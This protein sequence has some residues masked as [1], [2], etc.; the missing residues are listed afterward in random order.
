[1]LTYYQVAA[2]FPKNK[3]ILTYSSEESYNPGDLVEIPL[4]ARVAHGV[5]I[6]AESEAIEN[7]KIKKILGLIENAYSLSS[8][9]LEL[10]SWMSSYYH[11]PLGKLIFDSLPKVL[12]RPRK[13]S[14]VVGEN[15]EIPY[16][17]TLD[18]KKIYDSITKDL[19]S[20]Y[21]RH[22][23]HGVTGS[24][25][26]LIY[27]S[28]IKDVL[29]SGKSAQ[30]LLPEI[31]LTPQFIEMFKKHLGC[32]IYSYHSGVTPSEKYHIWKRLKSEE[33]PILVMGVRSSLFLPIENLGLIVV[34]EEHD[35]SF[36][37]Q[38][39]CPYNA[40]DVALKKGMI[41]KIPVILGSATPTVENFYS[42][43]REEDGRKYYPLKNRVGNGVLPKLIVKDVRGED[44]DL[45]T[46]PFSFET[47]EKIKERLEAGE[48]VLVFINKLG[49]SNYLQCRNCGHKFKNDQCGCENNLRYFKQKNILS[50]SHCDFTMKVPNSC[51]EC[52]SLSLLT[53]GFGTE[54]VEEVL[55]K[56]LHP[57][58]IDR[59]DRD[60]IIT[61]KDLN[62]KLEAFHGKKIDVLVGTQ[63]LSKGHNF[64]RV[65]LVVILGFDQ[66]LNY[67]DFRASEKA[68][69]LANQV[70]G[71]AGRYEGGGEVIIET[72]NPDH[73]L[74]K[75]LKD[76]DFDEFYKEE[77]KLRELCFCPPYS[78]IAMLYFS[79]RF[80]DRLISQV[81]VE[82]KKLRILSSSHFKNVKVLGPAPMSIEK[83]ANAYTW[84]I[85]LK[86]ADLKELHLLLKTF[87]D[88]VEEQSG[89]SYKIDVD[90]QTII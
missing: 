78:R 82:A 39:R 55:T 2:N 33:K 88:N 73:S 34:D 31:N 30:F 26:S 60:E 44:S 89:V 84:A 15:L 29:K 10:Y 24:G 40:R 37:Q 79:S 43:S 74:F 52:G 57:Y 87:V 70:M 85:M 58:K 86:S 75:Y 51:P 19:S 65:N 11:Y 53:K 61:L 38:D 22:Y 54:R 18:Q 25:K 13:P 49:F 47:L 3:S 1:M 41:F 9:E 12:Q 14:F 8:R 7:V 27:L 59:F 63:M 48:Q 81:T 28:L 72:M 42:Y 17:L 32:E 90:S 77:I 66:M 76:H 64:K 56:N 80:R 71:R 46:Y 50:C 83:K 23:I 69:Q 67:A 62:E 68:Y 5:V 16:S 20:G 6:K 45:E 36:K 35:H 4:G 21:S